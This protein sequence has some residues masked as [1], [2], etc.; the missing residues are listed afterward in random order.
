MQKAIT[1]MAGFFEKRRLMKLG[2]EWLRHGMLC[3]HMRED[4][5][6]P[7]DLRQLDVAR[8]DLKAVLKARE[9]DRVEKSCDMVHKAMLKLMP[10]KPFAGFRENLE[11]LVVAVAV[12]M[13]F[14]CYFLQPFKIPTGSMQPTL[15]GIHYEAQPEKGLLDLGPLRLVKWLAFGEWYTEVRAETAGVLRGPYQMRRIDDGTAVASYEIGGLELTLPEGLPLAVKVGDEVVTGQIIARGNKVNGDHLFVNRVKWNFMKPTRGEVMVF[16]TDGIVGLPS[17]THYIKRMCGLPG[18]TITIRAPELLVNGKVV[19]AP[20]TI[21]RIEDRAPGYAGYCLGDANARY[22][23]QS[24][25]SIKL[26]AGD[27]LALGD[28]T[29]NSADGRYWGPVPVD[30]LVGPAMV[31]YW[32][33]SKRWGWVH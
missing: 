26:G 27:Y 5:A 3:R 18:E 19:M 33:F 22:I 31:V 2:E 13:A 7:D 16:R 12:A 11:V 4:I 10:P 8:A 29:R 14:R 1:T 23:N 17:E 9:V 24:Q 20:D 32:P 25:D 15:Y 6:K 30:N 21:R 28:N